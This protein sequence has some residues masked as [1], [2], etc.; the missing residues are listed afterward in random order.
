MSTTS[1][2]FMMN[3]E[4]SASSH[5]IAAI[6][7]TPAQVTASIQRGIT[8]PRHTAAPTAALIRAQLAKWQKSSNQVMVS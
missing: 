8:V 2:V 3:V 7:P 1:V 5:R 4:Y 6:A